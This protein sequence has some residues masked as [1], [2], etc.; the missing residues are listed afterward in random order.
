MT[1]PLSEEF[2]YGSPD[3]KMRDMAK[4]KAD[5]RASLAVYYFKV[6]AYANESV[7]GGNDGIRRRVGQVRRRIAQHPG[8]LE[9]GRGASFGGRRGLRSFAVPARL[10][11]SHIAESR[12]PPREWILWLE[13]TLTA[14]R[15]LGDRRG[16]A[17]RPGPHGQRLLSSRGT[18]TRPSTPRT[19]PGD[20][21]GDRGPR[22]GGSRSRQS[23]QCPSR[24]RGRPKAIEFQHGVVGDCSG[25]PKSPRGG[26]HPWEP[27]VMLL[28]PSGTSAKAIEFQQQSL[29]IAREPGTA[30]AR[31]AP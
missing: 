15:Q 22:R 12:L 21:P 20:R 24:P 11:L 31:E 26:S 17:S 6:L 18:F 9:V 19:A 25:E 30:A 5:A 3:P 23:R 27:G 7:G 16:E 1:R 4:M 2:Q 28:S 29:A 8:Q 10:P 13:A 14:C